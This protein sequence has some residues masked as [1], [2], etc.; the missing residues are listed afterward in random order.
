[1]IGFIIVF[2]QKITKKIFENKIFSSINA[3]IGASIILWYIFYPFMILKWFIIIW[4]AGSV[5]EE[6]I[7]LGTDIEE[8]IKLGTELYQRKYYKNNLNKK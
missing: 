4:M 1:M 6:L 2:A 8:L 3:I 5:I 7:K